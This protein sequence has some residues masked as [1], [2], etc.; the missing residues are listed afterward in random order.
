MNST[1]N[2]LE[3][4]IYTARDKLK[5]IKGDSQSC[6]NNVKLKVQLRGA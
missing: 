2:T 6:T 1:N 4:T 5:Q 3:A